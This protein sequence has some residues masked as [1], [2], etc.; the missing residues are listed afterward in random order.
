[1]NNNYTK[2]RN[3]LAAAF[4]WTA[5]LKMHESIANH[6]SLVVSDD[7]S[8]FLVNPNGRHFSQIKASELLLL[9][10]N[11]NTTMSSKNAP[12]PTAWAIHSA[13]HRNNAQAKCVLHVHSKYATILAC[14]ENS[15]MPPI[16]QNTMR[17]YNRVSIDVGYDGMGL[18]NE[19]ERLSAKLG[20]NK[21]LLLGNHGVVVTAPSVAQAFDDLYYFER[22]C[23]TLIGAYQTGKKLRV[24]SHEVAEKTAQQWEN[25]GS[26]ANHHFNQLMAIL[27][28]EEPD[29]KC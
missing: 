2:E 21:I 16:D 22:A 13:I 5:R 11:D 14:L 25:Y 10:S 29:Y 15:V 1:M 6:F 28:K 17:F 18:A 20:S 9:D 4:R 26:F 24:A 19:A 12:D 3:E 8:Q 7:G 27:D 23:E